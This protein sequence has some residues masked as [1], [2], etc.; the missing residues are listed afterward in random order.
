M[1]AVS[2]VLEIHLPQMTQTPTEHGQVPDRSLG[3]LL[4]SGGSGWESVPCPGTHCAL[5]DPFT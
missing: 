1:G 2:L 5:W 3:L 4:C